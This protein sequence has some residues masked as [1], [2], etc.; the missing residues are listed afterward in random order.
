M[1]ADEGDIRLLKF[2]EEIVYL[3]ALSIH[4]M[5]WLQTHFHDDEWDD[6]AK[7]HVGLDY[8]SADKLS[9]DANMAG[10]LVIYN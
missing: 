5:L 2:S 6:I 4:G 7:G 9:Q 1:V 8:H 10:L 3:K